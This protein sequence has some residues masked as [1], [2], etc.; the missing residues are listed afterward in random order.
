MGSGTSGQ[1][2]TKVYGRLRSCSVLRIGADN[3]CAALGGRVRQTSLKA[4]TCQHRDLFHSFSLR[5]RGPC[6][7]PTTYTI[8]ARETLRCLRM[9]GWIV[10]GSVERGGPSILPGHLLRNC[11]TLSGPMSVAPC[12]PD[13]CKRIAGEDSAKSLAFAERPLAHFSDPHLAK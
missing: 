12:S 5:T 6:T 9:Y 8:P 3:A 11:A 10:P 4:I 13:S 1:D 7:A 2:L